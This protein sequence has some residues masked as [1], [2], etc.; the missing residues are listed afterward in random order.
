MEANGRLQGSNNKCLWPECP[1]EAFRH[2]KPTKTSSTP[3]VV[4]G[5]A[6]ALAKARVGGY[7]ITIVIVDISQLI[8]KI[9]LKS[10]G[11][12]H[13]PYLVS[14][15]CR[16]PG[17]APTLPRPRGRFEGPGG[18]GAALLR[19]W[20]GWEGSWGLMDCWSFLG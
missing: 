15:S 3:A 20:R 11:W 2:L 9:P 5:A 6:L 10:H 1:I 12:V 7:Y 16:S 8:R 14:K 13:S 18:G 17:G 4:S 19:R